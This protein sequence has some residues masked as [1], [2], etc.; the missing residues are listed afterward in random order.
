MYPSSGFLPQA[1]PWLPVMMSY[2][3]LKMRCFDDGVDP[4]KKQRLGR[5]QGKGC[6][7]RLWQRAAQV[8]LSR[9]S[10]LRNLCSTRVTFSSSSLESGSHVAQAGSQITKKPRMTCSPCCSLL[11]AGMTGVCHH[12][13]D[14]NQGFPHTRLTF[15][16]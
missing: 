7:G 12:A 2:I 13:E 10:C 15:V 5:M 4:N 1:P 9:V 11:R 6:T 14:E 16:N 3:T 8:R